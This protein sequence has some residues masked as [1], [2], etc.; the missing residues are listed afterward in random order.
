VP[1]LLFPLAY[2]PEIISASPWYN[3]FR[4]INRIELLSSLIA[5]AAGY[6]TYRKPTNPYG[7][8][9]PQNMSPATGILKPLAFPFCLILISVNFIG[10]LVR[11]INKEIVFTEAWTDDGVYLQTMPSTA[12]PSALISAM[13]FLNYY[14][15]D[16]YDVVKNTY[17]DRAGTEFWYLSRY[18]VNKGYRTKFIKPANVESAPVP[19]IVTVSRIREEDGGD[20]RSGSYIAILKRSD[21]GALTIGDPDAGKLELK[22]D[23]YKYAY[24]DPVL[25]LAI[26]A[27]RDR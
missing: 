18:A 10:P 4:S 27:P 22:P 24:G 26:S 15:D 17:T 25:A 8:Y 23:E 3:T 9:H 6:F 12:G 1:S 20:G 16:E 19:S 11:P 21:N 14:A 13:Y 7:A 2:L 5:P